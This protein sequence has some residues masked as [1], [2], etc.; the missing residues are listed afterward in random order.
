[1]TLYTD[2][3]K[4]L[5]GR[6]IGHATVAHD[7][8]ISLD[9]AEPWSGGRV[10][11]RV[12]AR[13]GRHGSRPIT[14]GVHC[15]AAWLDIAPQLVGQKPMLRPSTYWDI[16]TRSVPVWLDEEILSETVEV[17][18][19]DEVNW[20]HFSLTVPDGIPRAIEGT[21][22]AF[23]Y[24]IEARRQRAVGHAETSIP[25]LLVE[26]R[27]IPCVRV[28]TSPIGS[29]RLLDFRSELEEPG[30]GGGC[31][32]SFDERRPEDMP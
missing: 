20:R 9:V 18:P 14:V 32:I 16:R 2:I 1:V 30:E 22:V 23:R 24:R 8:A 25:L 15:H 31:S 5:E 28:E 10:E 26:R 13:E 29:W 21:F 3:P 7:F 4:E 6:M 11:G 17:G 19:L 27:T 12:E